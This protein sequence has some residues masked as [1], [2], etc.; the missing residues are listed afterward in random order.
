MSFRRTLRTS[1]SCTGIGLH[2]GR[3]AHLSIHPAPSG[4]GVRFV[5]TDLGAEIPATLEYL[6]GVEYATTLRKGE[7]SVGT[8]EHLLSA[9]FAIGVDD[10]RVEVDGPEVPILDGSSA[11]FVLL[12]HQAGLRAYGEPRRAITLLRPVEVQQGG[13]WARLLPAPALSVSYT[14]AF[15]H[16]LLRHQAIDL[17]VTL[18]SFVEQIAP[19]RTFGFLSEVEALQ[20]QGLARGGSLDNAIVIGD[21]A[22]LNG[23][24][25]FPDECV[26]HKVLD[27]IGDLA[28]LGHPLVARL[29]AYKAGHA[30]HV[31]LARALMA[32]PECWT[33]VSRTTPRPSAQLSAEA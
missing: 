3:P 24:L 8:V 28:L 33:L 19:A 30:V 5:R 12:I 31:A 17:G 22:I 1:V 21:G 2:S 13:K 32:R 29:E 6:D 26:R 23:D 4:Y 11:P 7:A 16:P 18:E 15:E 27:A 20:R 9:L 10:V 14:I 25:R